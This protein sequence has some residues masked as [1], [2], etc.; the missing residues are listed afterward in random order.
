MDI[1]LGLALT[2]HLSSAGEPNEMHPYVEIEHG[3]FSAGVY[4]NSIEAASFY[5]TYTLEHERWFA[6]DGRVRIAW[7]DV[8]PLP[9]SASLQFHQRPAMLAV[10]S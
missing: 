3:A 8:A 9:Y 10:F 1:I 4:L 5:A 6:D 2:M 7:P